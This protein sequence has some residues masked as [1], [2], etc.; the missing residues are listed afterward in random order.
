MPLG[1]QLFVA[2]GY[3]WGK[4]SRGRRGEQGGRRVS[5]VAC[6]GRTIA[7]SLRACWDHF[8]TMYRYTPPPEL[9]RG[10]RDKFCIV[11]GW[12]QISTWLY[13]L[14]IPPCRGLE[15]VLGSLFLR[16]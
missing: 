13:L 3:R 16:C 1:T 9:L 7:T 15:G 8:Y 12:G 2:G 14:F 10:C 6:G 4:G 5:C 11:S